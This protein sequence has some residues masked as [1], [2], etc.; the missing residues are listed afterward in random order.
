MLIPPRLVLL[1]PDLS[2]LH[3]NPLY[4]GETLAEKAVSLAGALAASP[5]WRQLGD[6]CLVVRVGSAPALAAAGRFDRAALARLGFLA[7]WL[8]E[9]ISSTRYL[10]HTAV[11][12]AVIR[13]ADALRAALGGVL[14][15]CDFVGI[16]RGGLIVQG[17]LSYALELDS[18]VLTRP[19][20]PARPLVVIDDCALTGSRFRQ[21]I[22]GQQ[23]SA[24]VFAHLCSPRPLRDALMAT[25]PRLTHVLAAMDVE[26]LSPEGT[27]PE[28]ASWSAE[29]RNRAPDDYAWIGRTGI[30]IFPWS[31]PDHNFWNPETGVMEWGWRLAPPELCLKNRTTGGGAAV[32][33]VEPSRGPWGPPA[34][35][36]PAPFED[37]I[38]LVDLTSGATFG[39]HGVATDVWRGLCA[40]EPLEPLAQRLAAEYDVPRAQVLEDAVAL[41]A[42]LQER[43]LLE[44]RAAPVT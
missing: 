16:P 7:R 35:V 22:A 12:A 1:A 6:G 28:R 42:Q 31:E 38:L 4:P 36:L 37:A 32:Q 25:D 24:V 17:L 14:H 30:V 21:F 29:M 23:R 8:E 33:V 40:G 3:A 27:E 9:G 15:E 18:G 20:D 41:V 13:L 43:G 39:L 34:H 44:H 5:I 11:T 26:E 19:A 10:D 2:F